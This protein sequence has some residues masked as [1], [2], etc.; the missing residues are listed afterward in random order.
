LK[1]AKSFLVYAFTLFFNALVS[2]ATFSLLTKHLS[3]VDYGIINLYNSFTIFLVPFLS[4]GVPFT[5]S[6]DYFKMDEVSY[7]KH[8]TNGLAIP[9]LSSVLFTILFLL[10]A[11]PIRQLL[12]INSFFTLILPASCLLIVLNEIILNT[13]RNKGRHFLFAGYSIVRNLAEIGLTILF[14]IGLGMKWEGRLLSAFLALGLGAV[15]VIILVTR[16]HYYTA[17]FS[18]S[19]IKNIVRIGMPFIPERLA[20]FVLAYSDRFFIDYYKGTGEV[21]FYGAGA[22]LALIVNLTI[23]TLNN[24]FY[25]VIYKK[26]TGEHYD[27]KGIKKTVFAYISLAAVATLFVIVFTPFI[28]QNFVGE[29]F[30]PGKKYAIFLTAGFFFWAVYN[31]FL[32]FLLNVKMNKTIMMISLA[33][34]SCSILLNFINVKIF[35]AIGATY[36]S[37][38]VYIIMAA[39]VVYFVH[40]RYGLNK[41][42][43]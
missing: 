7:R 4:V 11:S 24:T 39:L 32:A 34:M 42:F 23:L 31:V 13:I 15:V 27:Y 33:G 12:K 21:G 35:G 25:P 19:D 17:S 28:F 22:Q 18:K 43:D 1:T 20:I 6:V 9:V 3:E 16:W 10:F 2:F 29:V 5:L 40:R 8:F 41:I 14:V 36:T 38:T 26:L 30:Q 37:I